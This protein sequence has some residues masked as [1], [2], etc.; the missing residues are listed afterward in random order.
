MNT[1]AWK[2]GFKPLV[3]LALV[4]AGAYL[5]W[6]WGFCR[7]YVPP[8]YMAILTA[9]EGKDLPPGEILAKSGYKGVLEEPLGEGRHFR[10]PIL[11][12]HEIK[13]VRHIPAGKVG[14]VTAKVGKDLPP[15]EFLAN[16]GEK[17]VR[18]AV[19]VPGTYRLNPYGYDIQEVDAVNV[20]IGYVG[21]LTSLSGT[22]APDGMFADKTQKGVMADILQPGLYY[23][24]PN[25]YKIDV[26]EIGLNQVS[27]SGRSGGRVITKSKMETSNEAIDNLSANVLNK[28]M[29]KRKDY[30]EKNVYNVEA[31]QAQAADAWQAAPQSSSVGGR[32]AARKPAP[33]R[34]AQPQ[35]PQLQQQ[36]MIQAD[37]STT[38]GLSQFVEFPSRDGFEILLDMTVEFELQPEDISWVFM[39]YGDLPAVVDKIIMPQILSVS[40]L[41]GSMYKAQDFIMGE[42]REKF[43]NDLRDSLVQA[44]K[45]K[46]ILVHNSL[47]RHVEVP[48]DILQPIQQSSVAVEQNLTNKARQN[49]AQKKALLNTQETLIEQR[50]QEVMQETEKLV[51][52][53]GALKETSV[54]NLRAETERQVAEINQEKAAVAASITRCQGEA[55]AKVTTLVEGEKTRG[56]QLKSEALHDGNALAWMN[57]AEQ[58]NPQVSVQIL[59]AGP[60]TLWTDL[61]GARLGD[62]GGAQIVSP[63]AP[64]PAKR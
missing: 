63:A 32:M 46:R 27:F 29:E 56:I 3:V 51:A 43:Q 7:I 41:K 47:I 1:Q 38:F 50:R 12:D 11:Y 22:K 2:M 37:G 9:K 45:E 62:L 39:R 28:Q 14:I 26:L 36:A 35:A 25:A 60:G 49:T 17:G 40:R 6:L 21:V 42:G 64:S 34:P 33:G 53:T 23:L 44:L 10:N 31:Q 61:K 58:L 8:G 5:V 4:L 57:F 59:H 16:A 20:P 13:P 18:R 48:D 55:R 19:L 30:L 54:A 52:E 24:N 15:G